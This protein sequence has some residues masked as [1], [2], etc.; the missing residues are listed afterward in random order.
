MSTVDSMMVG[1][2]L[3]A[4][5]DDYFVNVVLRSFI[6]IMYNSSYY[7][8]ISID[9]IDFYK[10]RGDF[11]GVLDKNSIPKKYH[12]FILKFNGGVDTCTFEFNGNNYFF[13]PD[14][15]YIESLALT[16]VTDKLS[17]M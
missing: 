5:S 16:Y 14:L 10:Y 3:D 13:L 1:Q 8:T 15:N 9:P 6:P 2:P 4:F 7:S 11:Y 17:F 12:S